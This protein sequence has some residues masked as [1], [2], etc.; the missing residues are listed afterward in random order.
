MESIR[1]CVKTMRS[2]LS[3]GA[4]L[5][6]PVALM[7]VKHVHQ[8]ASIQLMGWTHKLFGKSPS[9]HSASFVYLCKCE[10]VFN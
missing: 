3:I 4:V 1:I 10:E 9:L 8:G 5:L 2:I 6:L 7:E